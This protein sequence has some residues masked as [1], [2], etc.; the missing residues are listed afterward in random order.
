M[1]GGRISLNS[2]LNASDTHP[3]NASAK[4]P[5]SAA[6]PPSVATTRIPPRL[7]VNFPPYCT[8]AYAADSQASFYPM[9]PPPDFSKFHDAGSPGTV[10]VPNTPQEAL[11]PQ[12]QLGPSTFQHTPHHTATGHLCPSPPPASRAYPLTGWPDAEPEPI[13]SNIPMP[14]APAPLA[15]LHAAGRSASPLPVSARSGRVGRAGARCTECGKP[16]K[17][18]QGAHRHHQT[19]HLKLRPY[20]CPDCSHRFGQKC[21]LQRHQR[22][23]HK[24][25]DIRFGCEHVDCPARFADYRALQAHIRAAHRGA[26][27]FR[28]RV[29]GCASSFMW[30]DSLTRHLALA[31]G[32]PQESPVL[33]R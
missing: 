3:D 17:T 28:C 6:A 8:D 13:F 31:H 1:P 24:R 22:S 10:K 15:P 18:K 23:V 19:V 21:S 27:P 12:P 9:W 4:P 26:P 29:P 7:A 14:L 20:G 5:P 2:I 32:V 25:R 30:P 33:D 16:F 11:L